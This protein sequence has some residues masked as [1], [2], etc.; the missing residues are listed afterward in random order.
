MIGRV[1][2]KTKVLTI[3]LTEHGY[4]NMTLN[5]DPVQVSLNL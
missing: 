4:A 2:N 5:P 1:T 3:N